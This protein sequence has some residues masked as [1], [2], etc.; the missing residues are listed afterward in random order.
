MMFVG[1]RNNSESAN[2]SKI[3]I[4]FDLG[5]RGRVLVLEVYSELQEMLERLGNPSSI[6]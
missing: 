2:F 1:K 4:N 3:G 6:P 5:P